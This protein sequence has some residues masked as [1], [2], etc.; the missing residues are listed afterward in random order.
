MAELQQDV[1]VAT[2]PLVPLAQQ[3]LVPTAGQV[4]AAADGVG[5]F[6]LN[7]AGMLATLSFRFPAKPVDGQLV[8]IYT[9]QEIL[10][11]TLLPAAGQ[12]IA[13]APA[14][15]LLG[16][17]RSCINYRAVFNGTA[18]ATWYCMDPVSP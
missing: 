18:N 16:V 2:R 8:S 4:I 17:S 10:L 9:S 13:R 3:V 14:A 5:L 6:V 1:A 7:P 11:L 12:T 15:F